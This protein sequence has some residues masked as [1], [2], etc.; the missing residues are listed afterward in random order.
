MIT[1]KDFLSI[2]EIVSEEDFNKVLESFSDIDINP[3]FTSFDDIYTQDDIATGLINGFISENYLYAYADDVNF[4]NKTFEICDVD[5]INDLEEIKE[6][7]TNWTI[8]NFDEVKNDLIEEE[9]ERNEDSKYL[10]KMNL[11]YNVIDKIPVEDLKNFI[12]KYE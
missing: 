8:R 2:N 10:Q 3:E 9:K 1:Y 6:S 11:I 4:E 7:F 12:S 5:N